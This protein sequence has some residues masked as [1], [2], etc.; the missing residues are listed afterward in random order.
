MVFTAGE[1]EEAWP[2]GA[3]C[4]VTPRGCRHDEDSAGVQSRCGM[5]CECPPYLLWFDGVLEAFR[6][7]Y[8]NM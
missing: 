4:G 6:L 2:Y 3:S 5:P 1:P 8:G 7:Q